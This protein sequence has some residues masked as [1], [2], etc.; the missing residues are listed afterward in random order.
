[1]CVCLHSAKPRGKHGG[2]QHAVNP[3]VAPVA[4]RHRLETAQPQVHETASWQFG[5]E[6]FGGKESDAQCASCAYFL[7]CLVTIAV[8]GAVR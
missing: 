6:I 5:C 2:K 3:R 8:E 4:L 7:V 1:M